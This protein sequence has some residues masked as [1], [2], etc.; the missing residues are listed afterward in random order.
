MEILASIWAEEAKHKEGKEQRDA[1]E[2]NEFADGKCRSAT[3]L[4]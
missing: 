1:G 2:Q 3:L 4:V